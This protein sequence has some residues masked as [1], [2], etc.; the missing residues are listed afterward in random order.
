MWLEGRLV[1]SSQ[2]VRLHIAN[3]TIGTIEE[4]HTSPSTSLWIAPGWIDIQVNGSRP[5]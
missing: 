4:I 3:G 5:F 1:E 2:P